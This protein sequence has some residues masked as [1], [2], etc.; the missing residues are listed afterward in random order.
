MERYKELVALLNKYAYDYHVLDAPSVSDAVY[1]GLYQ[2]LKQYEAAHPEDVL[3]DSP[4]QRVGSELR[5]GFAK[6]RHNSRMLSLNDVFNK[7]DVEAWVKRMDKLLPGTRHE[8]FCA[9]R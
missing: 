3:P 1:D 4:S 7:S 2:E 5:G 6:V 9:L 8:F